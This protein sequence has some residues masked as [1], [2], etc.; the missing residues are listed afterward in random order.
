L[1]PKLALV[2]FFLK[3]QVCGV[4][5]GVWTIHSLEQREPR[6]LTV[7]DS[8]EVQQFLVGF[9]LVRYGEVVYRHCWEYYFSEMVETNRPMLAQAPLRSFPL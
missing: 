4:R 8:P 5:F 9:R 7:Q 3:V 2:V 1:L 6:A